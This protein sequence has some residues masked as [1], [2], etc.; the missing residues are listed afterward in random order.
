MLEMLIHVMQ[1]DIS[2][3]SASKDNSPNKNLKQLALP[4]P[5]HTETERHCSVLDALLSLGLYS[6]D[7]VS[8]QAVL[9]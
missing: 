4:F 8:Y 2:S 3:P 7:R 5:K 9:L 6:K 1:G